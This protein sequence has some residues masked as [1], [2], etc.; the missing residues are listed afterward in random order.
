[1]LPTLSARAVSNI[2]IAHAFAKT[3]LVGHNSPWHHVWVALPEAVHGEL[4]HFNPQELSNVVWAFAKAGHASAELFHAI[5]EVVHRRLGCFNGQDLSNTLWAF[6]KAGHA[7]P[8]LFHAIS[9]E[10]VH[11]GLDGYDPQHLSNTAW[12]FATAGHTS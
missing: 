12:A 11:R 3:G 8:K 10:M 1:M 4:G 2:H 9:A 5:S 6:A 7:S